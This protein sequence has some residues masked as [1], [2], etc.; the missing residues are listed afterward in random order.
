MTPYSLVERQARPITYKTA[1][2]FIFIAIR[3]ITAKTT[4]FYFVKLRTKPLDK[5]YY[6]AEL[7]Y[8]ADSSS[9]TNQI[10]YYFFKYFGLVEVIYVMAN[11]AILYLNVQ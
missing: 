4:Q 9:D 11:S 10:N 5:T 6:P 3:I 1:A 2:N 7:R 8:G